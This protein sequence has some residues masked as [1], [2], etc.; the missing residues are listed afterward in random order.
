MNQA[1]TI[2]LKKHGEVEPLPCFLACV[3][4]NNGTEITANEP[5]RE[6]QAASESEPILGDAARKSPTNCG[7]RL[8]ALS[9]RERTPREATLREE[10]NAGSSSA[11]LNDFHSDQK[12]NRFASGFSE[13]FYFVAESGCES[14][15]RHG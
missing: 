13:Y 12:V 6:R 4:R 8:I 7:F 5:T 15:L 10:L 1:R 14:E 3:E 11:S 9:T 2:A